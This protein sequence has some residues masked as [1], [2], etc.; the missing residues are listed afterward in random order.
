[1]LYTITVPSKDYKAIEQYLKKGKIL[2]PEI[3]GRSYEVSGNGITVTAEIMTD[4]HAMLYSVT[5]DDEVYQ[6]ILMVPVCYFPELGITVVFD[7]D[8]GYE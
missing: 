6:K 5:C 2:M 8:A 7:K 3:I 1:M 4:K